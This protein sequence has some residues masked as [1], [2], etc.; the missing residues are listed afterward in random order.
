VA[1]AALSMAKGRQGTWSAAGLYPV[2]EATL[3]RAVRY[4]KDVGFEMRCE[5][6]ARNH[7]NYVIYWPLTLEY[8]VP[9]RLRSCRT[10]LAQRRKVYDRR[11]REGRKK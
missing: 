4:R 3:T 7:R 8:W 9:R 6:C 1:F 5:S 2:E 11:Y 10:C